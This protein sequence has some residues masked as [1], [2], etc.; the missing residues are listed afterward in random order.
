MFCEHWEAVESLLAGGGEVSHDQT[1]FQEVTLAL[2]FCFSNLILTFS[3][4]VKNDIFEVIDNREM[5]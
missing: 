3:L 2:L 4:K 1:L 5:K